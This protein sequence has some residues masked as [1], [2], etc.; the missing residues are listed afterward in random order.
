MKTT[1][2]DRSDGERVWRTAFFVLS[3]VMAA[4]AL[5]DFEAGRFA[6]GL[7]D[8]G[9]T[10]L[11]LSLMVQFPFL[12]SIVKASNVPSTSAEAVRRQREE[13][14]KQAEQLRAANPWAEHASRAGWVLLA[15]SLLMRMGGAA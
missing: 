7:G 2:A 6:K 14:T 13:L 15:L 10:L 8:T 3:A 12:R 1:S 11:M 4:T 5:V 9:V